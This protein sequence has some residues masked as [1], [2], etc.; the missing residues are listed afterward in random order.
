M[1][2]DPELI[3]DIQCS[4]GIEVKTKVRA[5]LSLIIAFS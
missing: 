3:E 2:V 4:T 1:L 5:L